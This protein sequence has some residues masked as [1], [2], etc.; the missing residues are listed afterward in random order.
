[1]IKQPTF[2]TGNPGPRIAII[3]PDSN[4]GK[5]I[6]IAMQ[7]FESTLCACQGLT[8]LRWTKTEPVFADV[9]VLP[10]G[11][12]REQMD[13]W[14]ARGKLLVEIV[15]DTADVPSDI[16]RFTLVYPFKAREALD[17]LTR[18]ERRL[19]TP[20]NSPLAGADWGQLENPDGR[21]GD[22]WAFVE[23]LRTIDSSPPQ[24]T[25]F[26]G[27][28]R[29]ESLLWLCGDRP[30][31]FVA[32][33]AAQAIR[34]GSE[35]LDTMQLVPA[36]HGSTPDPV[37]ESRPAIEL[38]WFA[39]YHASAQPAPWLPP[40]AKYQLVHWPDFRVIAPARSQ[41]RIAATLSFAPVS[42]KQLAERTDCPLEEVTR[43]L[44]ALA[45]CGAVSFVEADA[46]NEPLG[47]S[48][49]TTRTRFRALFYDVR[50]FLRRR[51]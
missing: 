50:Q 15:T 5:R 9:V 34:N 13:S 46:A 4:A 43:T 51:I 44:N 47:D 18:I 27:R 20:K 41:R 6:V 12:P 25:W 28:K 14:N 32:P 38:R 33:A 21:G 17:L 3:K 19:T 1:M 48:P 42:L 11:Y 29:G 8:K 37:C 31:Y 7:S 16:G 23:S 39:G 36:V 22:P 2:I 35:Q 40:S 26:I 24:K 49:A 10:H 45:T 30:T